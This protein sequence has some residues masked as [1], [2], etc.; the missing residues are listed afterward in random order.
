MKGNEKHLWREK[1]RKLIGK[2]NK[3]IWN[4]TKQKVSMVGA[5]V[6]HGKHKND[7]EDSMGWT[8]REKKMRK[9]SKKIEKGSDAG[10]RRQTNN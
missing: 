5:S 4:G 7:Q 8:G 10:Y 1:N 2:T 6:A 9:T 3:Y